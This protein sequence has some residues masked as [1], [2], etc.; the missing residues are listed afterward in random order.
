M[1]STSVTM[2]SAS[3]QISRVSM[4]SSEEACCS[5]SCAAPRM[6]D[7]GFLISCASIAASAITER[8][9]LR[10]VS[11]RSILSAMVRS[12]SITTI[13]PGRSVSGATC[14]STWR[15]PPMRG[16]PRSTLYSLTGEPLGAH[17]VD[18]RQQRT[19]ERHQLLQ[20]LPLQELGRNL[21]EG[22]GGDVG[23]D[24]LAVG[25]HQQHRIGQR[26]EDGLARRRAR[27]GDVL[28]LRS[29]SST[30]CKIV[31][32]VLER[33][34]HAGRIFRGQDRLPPALQRRR[35]RAAVLR[36]DVER[37]AEMFSRMAKPD[38][39]AVMAADLVIER[40]DMAELLGERRA[41]SRPRRSRAGARSGRAARAAPARRG[42]SSRHRR[43][44]SRA[45]CTAFSNEVISP[46]TTSGIEIAS[47]TAR[48]AAQSASPL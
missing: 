42:R 1:R 40:A 11:C 35:R 38:A 44:I 33:A 18:Q 48:T 19:A 36:R 43:R 2:R 13:W 32:G 20:R 10:W 26:V 17:L 46:L 8:A 22:F 16:V 34:M 39:Q 14:R 31:E 25:R 5:S 7:S 30:P 28:R 9:A 37:P 21:E 45:R 4:R 12:C 23:V 3:S 29:C 6:P 41:R 15:S 27:A 47:L 24:D